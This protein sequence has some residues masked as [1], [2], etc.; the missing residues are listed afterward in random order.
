M[1]PQDGV[2]NEESFAPCLPRAIA[3]RYFEMSRGSVRLGSRF[4]GTQKWRRSVGK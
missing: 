2:N 1:Q 3:V 4:L